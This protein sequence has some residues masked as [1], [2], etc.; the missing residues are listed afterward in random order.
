MNEYRIIYTC[1]D[2]YEGEEIVMAVN[3]MMAFEVFEDLGIEDVVDADCFRVLDNV[4][5]N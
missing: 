4:E 1:S 3:R 2:G 5:E